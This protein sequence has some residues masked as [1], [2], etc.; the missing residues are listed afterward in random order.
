MA[1]GR[2]WSRR[3]TK[4]EP[5]WGTVDAKSQDLCSWAWSLGEAEAGSEPRFSDSFLKFPQQT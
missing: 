1:W 2:A 3:G 4:P 5:G